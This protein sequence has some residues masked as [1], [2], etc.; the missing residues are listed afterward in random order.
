MGGGTFVELRELI[1]GGGFVILRSVIGGGK[2][3]RDWFG[4]GQWI[5]NL[6][7]KYFLFAG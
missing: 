2:N 4:V 5:Y 3:L 7:K 1:S 6:H